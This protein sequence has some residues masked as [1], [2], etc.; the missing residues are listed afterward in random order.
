MISAEVDMPYYEW[1]CLAAWIVFGI[2]SFFYWWREEYDVTI[3]VI[4]FGVF[5]GSIMGVFSY[6][7]GRALH[8]RDRAP[9][10]I[11]KRK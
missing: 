11:W 4:I 7:M 9:F 1:M 3:G 6:P 10:V 5:V 2:W 8:G